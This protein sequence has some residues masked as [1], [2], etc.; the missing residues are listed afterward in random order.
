MGS[1][2]EFWLEGLPRGL[3]QPVFHKFKSDL[4]GALMS[5]GAAVA[6]ELGEGFSVSK[7]RGLEFHSSDQSYGGLRGGLT[8]GKRVVARVAFKPPSSLRDVA[9]KGRHDPC[10]GPRAVPVVEAMA[11]LVVADHI[12]WSRLDRV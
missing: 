12:L 1:L 8:T 3:G 10:I 9:Q 7:K 2:V 5:V 6:F 4:A 11:C